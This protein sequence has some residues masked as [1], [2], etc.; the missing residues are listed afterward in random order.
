MKEN[1]FAKEMREECEQKKTAAR[2]ILEISAELRLTW[3]DFEEIRLSVE[4][5]SRD[6]LLKIFPGRFKSAINFFA[7]FCD[8]V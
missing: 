8:T 7:V 5:V 4:H 3:A 6:Y 2:R 1:N